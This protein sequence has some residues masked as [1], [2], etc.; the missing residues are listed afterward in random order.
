MVMAVGDG[1]SF[2]VQAEEDPAALSRVL[3]LFTLNDLM[4]DSINAYRTGERDMTI[5]LSLDGLEYPQAR[6]FAAKISRIVSVAQVRLFRATRKA[7]ASSRGQVVHLD[8][9]AL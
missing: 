6:L 9:V 1:Y 3:E 4:P 5:E 2:Q 8:E 7:I